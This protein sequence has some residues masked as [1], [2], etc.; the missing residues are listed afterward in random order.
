MLKIRFFF[1]LTITLLLTAIV[2]L[3]QPARSADGI[4]VPM[5]LTA[6]NGVGASVGEIN[7]RNTQYGLLLTPNLRGLTPGLHG[8][9]VHQNPAC[10]SGEKNGAIVPGLA[11]GGHFDPTQQGLHAGPYENGHLGDL[12]SL[13]VG[14]D[15]VANVPV[16]APRLAISDVWSRS[17]ILH[18]NGD[19]FSDDPPSGGGGP[20]LA[21]GVIYY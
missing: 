8:F 10:G 16:L 19:N 18:A 4:V 3:I 2:A 1:L 21:C 11:A 5:N 9:H 13:Y 20:R 6:T 15:G 12:P 14:Q 7:L 17:L